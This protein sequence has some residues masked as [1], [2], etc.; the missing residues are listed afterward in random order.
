MKNLN[1]YA[2][3]SSIPKKKAFASSVL[4]VASLVSHNLYAASCSY[5]VQDEWNNGFK[6]EITIFNDGDSFN[7]WTLSWQWPD[8]TSLNNSWNAEFSCSTSSCTATPPSWQPNIE[9]GQSYKFGFTAS[10]LGTVEQEV[11]VNGDVCDASVGNNY[12]IAWL[13]DGKNSSLNYVSVK[14]EHTAETNTFMAAEGEADALNGSISRSGEAILAIDLNDVETFN[15]TRDGRLLTYLFETEFLPT[16]YLTTTVDVANLSDMSVGEINTQTLTGDLTIHAVRQAVSAQVMVI[17]TSDTTFSVNT[18]EPILISSNSFDLSSGIEVLRTIA[19]LSSIG[20]SVPVYLSLKFVINEDENETGVDMPEVPNAPTN[21]AGYFDESELVA[22]LFWD[23][24]SNNETLYLVRR[25]LVDGDWETSTELYENLTAMSE[26]LPEEGEY[27]YKVIAVNNS[28]PSDPTEEVRISVTAGNQIVRGK[29]IF[30]SQCTGCH[31]ENGEGSLI[32]P[33][34]NTERDVE[35]MTAIILTSMP[36]GN[37]GECDQACAEDAAAYIETLWVTEVACDI[38]LTPVSYGARQLKILT[39]TEYQNSVED[40]I[41]IDYQVSEGL[42]ADTKIGFFANNTHSSLVASSYSNFLLVAEEIAQWS[43]DNNFAPALSCDTIDEAC[44]NQLIDTLAPKIFRRPLSNDE[45][46]RYLEMA[47]GTHTSGDVHSGIQLAL[48]AL[49]SSPQFIYRHELGELNPANPDIDSNAYELTSYEMATFLAY[50]F[51]ASTPDDELLQAAANDELRDEANI[52]EHAKRLANSSD[53]VMGNFIGAWLGTEDLD[54]SAKDDTLW[55]GFDQLV[56]HMQKELNQT[57]A[58]IMTEP[59]ENYSS[60]YGGNFT[61]LNQTLAQHYGISGVSGDE[62][63]KVATI[64]RGGILANGAFMSRWGEAVE[65][66]PILRSVRVRR[67]MLCQDQPDPPAGTFAAREAKLEELSD[68]LQDLSTTNRLKYHRLTED[69]PC[70]NCHSQYINPLGFGM[71]DFDTVGR[72]RTADLNGNTINATGDLYAPI[73]YNDIDKFESFEGAKGLGNILTGLTSAQACL[74][75]QMFRYFLGV[76]HQS[77]DDDNPE[78]DTL[79]DEEKSGYSCEVDEL[80]EALVNHS[81]R[82]ML[83]KFGSLE[84]VRYRKEWSRN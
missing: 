66:S 23:D 19:G 4:L 77:I 72:V 48:E 75:K 10:H 32:F 78:G 60:L 15:D 29:G 65:T 21:L 43:A 11:I 33:A 62:L 79:T 13:L 25:K 31:G 3:L 9:K 45:T 37:P 58:Y 63:Q 16:A 53:H 82:A 46:T 71:E 20:E 6:A 81:P 42:S 24:N 12:N 8:G 44:A 28:V 74:P 5:E 57:F 7:D 61:F 59:T 49:L 69:A 76:G 55:P 38:N 30:E 67:R 73:N 1:Q 41:G 56:P 70:T 80:T 39:R 18:I 50:T 40:L 2:F 34:L 52:L 14:K 51:T 84:A 68:L 27:D 26:G 22:S 54:L 64:D 47:V 36:Y 17:K 35:E 83:E